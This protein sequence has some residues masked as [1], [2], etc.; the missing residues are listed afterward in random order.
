MA[1]SKI[2]DSDACKQ[3]QQRYLA[4]YQNPIIPGNAVTRKSQVDL[5]LT[6]TKAVPLDDGHT[7][8][9]AG[10][11]F[12]P[13][14]R[15]HNGVFYI[16]CTNVACE[17]V[18][19]A[20]SNFFITTTDIWAGEWSEPVNVD[21]H[22]ID[23]SLFIDTDGRAYMQGSW[24]LPRTEQPN[25]TI[26]Q[27][28]INLATGERIGEPK[29]IWP[30]YSKNYTEGPHIY[31][32]DGWYYLLVAEGGTFEHHHLSI[33]RAR[34]IWGPYDSCPSN[35]ILT[36]KN[37]NELVQNVG[38][39]ELFQ[40]VDGLWWATVLGVRKYND[41]TR[42]PLGRESFLT[43]VD[44]PEGQ[45]PVIEHPRESF[46]RVLPVPRAKGITFA[47]GP[48][49][50]DCYIRS[51]VLDDYRFESDGRVRLRP[52]STDLAV[53][54]GTTTFVGQRQRRLSGASATAIICLEGIGQSVRTGLA[55]Y[56]DDF[57]YAAVSVESSS[58]VLSQR[59]NT[60]EDVQV[61]QAVIDGDAMSISFSV[62][63]TLKEYMFAYRVKTPTHQGEWEALGRIDTAEMTARDFTGTIF[64][65]FAHHRDGADGAEWVSFTEFK[66][67]P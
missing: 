48:R 20:A 14:I 47:Q 26:K 27:W 33:A 39:G 37:K 50:A 6:L 12:A 56:K 16:I 30:G 55:V 58:V 11:L 64:G 49:V 60:A 3:G 13:T 2:I 9:G 67:A 52:S 25:T 66:I 32:K 31:K 57:R 23:P 18:D 65:I 59:N 17:G 15:H 5:T 42:Y 41:G 7:M 45:W 4:E 10:G 24:R 19:F 22:G 29:D 43:P 35:P 1:P 21:L 63:A 34:D 46:R 28:E 40:G 54:I 36:A 44:W 53:P 61:A 51:P 8:I 38:H 62:S